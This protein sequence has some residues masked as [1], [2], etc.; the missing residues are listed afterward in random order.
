M[1]R[2]TQEKCVCAPLNPGPGVY[3]ALTTTIY[4]TRYKSVQ[5]RERVLTS[6]HSHQEYALHK[7]LVPLRFHGGAPQ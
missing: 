4:T 7:N 2:D 6:T 3:Q 1:T 5:R